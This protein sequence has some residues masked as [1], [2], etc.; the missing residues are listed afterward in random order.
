MKSNPGPL[1]LEKRTYRRRRMAD[2]AR[3]LPV[4]GTILFSV[5][6]L[7]GQDPGGAALTTSVMLYVFVVWGFLVALS[8]VISR[9]LRDEDTGSAQDDAQTKTGV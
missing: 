6:L 5:P 4:F 8:A 9:K 1:F 7:W 3:I 2:A